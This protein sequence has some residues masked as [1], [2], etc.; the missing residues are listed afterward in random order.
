MQLYESK[1][2][3]EILMQLLTHIKR[4]SD[5]HGTKWEI[6]QAYEAN[7]WRKGE[8][9]HSLWEGGGVSRPKKW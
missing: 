7:K 3:A 4:S 5:G 9:N 2:Y 6:L 1:D 8:K